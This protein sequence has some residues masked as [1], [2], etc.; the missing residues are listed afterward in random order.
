MQPLLHRLQPWRGRQGQQALVSGH[1]LCLMQ[2]SRMIF[3][4]WTCGRLT[5]GL[6]PVAA[7]AAGN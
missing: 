2:C 6:A 5:L 3:W 1:P 7:A 4:T